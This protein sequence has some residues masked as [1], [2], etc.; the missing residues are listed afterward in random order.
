M[1]GLITG[2]WAA[3]AV[4]VAATLGVAD[5]LARG[6]HRAEEITE[7]VD[8][9]P[10]AL[11]RLLR[12]L[13]GLGLV[14]ESGDRRFTLTELGEPLRTDAPA[15]LRGLAIMVGAPWHRRIWTELL[16]SVRTGDAAFV[17][18][19]GGGEYFDAHPEDGEVLNN[20]LAAVLSGRPK[21]RGVLFDLPSVIEGAG[22]PLR[23]AEVADRSE[24][25]GG[26]FF[27]AVPRA[28]TPTCTALPR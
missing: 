1:T 5:Q 13:S 26:D 20:A 6:P 11:Y 4:S 19:F 16:E 22:A 17:R 27:E 24:L 15:S 8:A 14:E 25:V 7:A 12:A 2:A 3:Q 10:D 28:V 21:A 9:D 23:E 18:L